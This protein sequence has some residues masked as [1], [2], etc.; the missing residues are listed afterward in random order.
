MRNNDKRYKE[1]RRDLM[2]TIGNG[3]AATIDGIVQKTEMQ[4]I[5]MRSATYDFDKISS[6]DALIR[7]YSDGFADMVNTYKLYG[8]NLDWLGKNYH[9][10][11]VA[12]LDDSIVYVT[13]TSNPPIHD[14]K[15]NKYVLLEVCSKYDIIDPRFELYDE[16]R[17][18]GQA[19]SPPIAHNVFLSSYTRS[20]SG[21]IHKKISIEIKL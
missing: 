1:L 6:V 3:A 14:S 4:A 10:F 12:G 2:L 19:P 17:A 11:L 16:A 9:E 21:K 20:V 5:R 18:K 8:N 7:A 13:F 15:G